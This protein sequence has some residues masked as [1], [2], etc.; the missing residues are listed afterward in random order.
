MDIGDRLGGYRIRLAVFK[1]ITAAIRLENSRAPNHAKN[2]AIPANGVT[3]F[4][5]VCNFSSSE[6]KSGVKLSVSFCAA[7]AVTVFFTSPLCACLPARNDF[8]QSRFWV[9]NLSATASY[10]ESR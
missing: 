1:S 5:V 6:P 3:A 9:K 8:F 10:S 2:D 7:W 4:A